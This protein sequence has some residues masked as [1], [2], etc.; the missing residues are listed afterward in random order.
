M[1]TWRFALLGL[2]WCWAASR[3]L[4]GPAG[5]AG[6][7]TDPATSR[8]ASELSILYGSEKKTLGSEKKTWL[9]EQIKAFHAGKARPPTAARST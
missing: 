3:T 5:P 2:V 7:S 8:P 4:P 6:P 1:K 9:E